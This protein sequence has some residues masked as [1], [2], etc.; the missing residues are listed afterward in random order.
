MTF[1]AALKNITFYVKYAVLLFGQLWWKIWLIFVLT[2]GHTGD[3]PILK[4]KNNSRFFR[5]IS[6][7]TQLRAGQFLNHQLLLTGVQNLLPKMGCSYVQ[8]IFYSVKR[9]NLFGYFLEAS[10]CW[11]KVP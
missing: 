7:L 6:T 10:L 11:T 2:T 3:D 8:I 4:L 9:S 1:G 5:K